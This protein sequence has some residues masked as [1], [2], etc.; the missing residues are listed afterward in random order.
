MS[1]SPKVKVGAGLLV[2]FLAGA[3][4]GSWVHSY[5]TGRIFVK[6]LD[7]TKWAPT[8]LK[9]LDDEVQLSPEQKQ[10]AQVLLDQTVGTVTGKFA[11]IGV[12]LVRLH[13]HIQS[14]LTPE[15]REKDAKSFE[16]FRQEMDRLRISLPSESSVTNAASGAR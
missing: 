7:S 10:K 12:E 4:C 16:R 1:V 9:G 13:I 14:I 5:F 3:V 15:Q 11:D 8:I 2:V 6:S